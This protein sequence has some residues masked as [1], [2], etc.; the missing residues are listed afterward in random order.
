MRLVRHDDQHEKQTALFIG[1]RR[2]QN[3]E[4][5]FGRLESQNSRTLIGFRIFFKG[6]N[7]IRLQ[8]CKNA[9]D[10]LLHIRAIQGCT[11]GNMIAPELMCHVTIPYQWKE[12]PVSS[13]ILTSGLV[14][15]GRESKEGRQTIFFAPLNPFGDSPDEEETGDDLSKPRKIHYHSKWKARQDAVYWINLARAQDKGPQLWQ[16]RSHAVIVCG[17]EPAD[18]IYKK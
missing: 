9:R 14:A 3:F 5:R 16:T 11:G 12:L 18:C 8:Y 10:L 15:G 7:K 1:N 2:V 17:S 4:K 6:S 13:R